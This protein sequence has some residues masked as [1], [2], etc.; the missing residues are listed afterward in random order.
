MVQLAVVPAMS[1]EQPISFTVHQEIAPA[2]ERWEDGSKIRYY[3][4]VGPV[5]GPPTEEYGWDMPMVET[6]LFIR[7]LKVGT[8]VKWRNAAG[9][10]VGEGT[11]VSAD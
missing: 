4:L 7:D 6:D 9:E 11:T 10:I 3:L 5:D 1:D 8:H 2:G